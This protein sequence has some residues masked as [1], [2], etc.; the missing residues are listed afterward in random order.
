MTWLNL[1]WKFGDKCEGYF[2]HFSLTQVVG[3]HYFGKALLMKDQLAN[4]HSVTFRYFVL[5]P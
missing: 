3:T 4:L 5:L 2:C 1:S